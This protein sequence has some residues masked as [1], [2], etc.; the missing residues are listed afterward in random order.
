[1]ARDKN[2][3]KYLKLSDKLVYLYHHK[4]DFLI[5]FG[6]SPDSDPDS[7]IDTEVRKMLLNI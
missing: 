5:K 2:I 1:M 4:E 7:I 3:D 6:A